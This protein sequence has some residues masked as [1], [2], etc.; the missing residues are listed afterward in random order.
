MEER[1]AFNRVV[2]GS[3]PTLGEQFLFARATFCFDWLWGEGIFFIFMYVS[4]DSQNHV[5]PPLEAIIAIAD[6]DDYFTQTKADL[7]AI[8]ADLQTEIAAENLQFWM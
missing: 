2:V 5:W 3:I 6:E 4:W 1:S 8:V 7:Q